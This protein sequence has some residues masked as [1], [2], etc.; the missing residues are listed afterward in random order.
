MSAWPDDRPCGRNAKRVADLPSMHFDHPDLG[1]LVEELLF[2]SRAKAQ[3]LRVP[4]SLMLRFTTDGDVDLSQCQLLNCAAAFRTEAEELGLLRK[5]LAAGEVEAFGA[6]VNVVRGALY[7]AGEIPTLAVNAEHAD[8]TVVR[9]R[10]HYRILEDGTIAFDEPRI[11]SDEELT[12]DARAEPI[13]GW[14]NTR[15]S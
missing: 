10:V 1:P 12:G 8:G 5:G 11:V 4:F 7:V 3:E 13:G 14:S 2:Y 15:P 6:C 9:V